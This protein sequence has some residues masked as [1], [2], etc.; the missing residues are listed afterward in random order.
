M[1]RLTSNCEFQWREPR[2]LLQTEGSKW[3][4]QCDPTFH[5]ILRSEIKMHFDNWKGKRS[6]KQGHPLFLCLSGPGTGK[7]RLL[8]EFPRLIKESISGIKGLEQFVENAFVF[9]ISF[10]NGTSES[11]STQVSLLELE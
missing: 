11:P 1:K 10:E 6:D 5:G 3:E 7:S 9:N 2:P 8:N 4:Y